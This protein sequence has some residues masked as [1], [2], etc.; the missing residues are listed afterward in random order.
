MDF[1]CRASQAAEA[2]GKAEAVAVSAA[3]L[4]RTAHTRAALAAAISANQAYNEVLPS[5]LTLQ[6]PHMISEIA[7]GPPYH[8]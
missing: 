8:D 7:P 1:G 6:L 2:A 4:A 3:Q 5:C